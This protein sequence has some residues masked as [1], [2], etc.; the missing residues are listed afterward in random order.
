[1]RWTV[2]AALALGALAGCGP[3]KSA[4][5]AKGTTIKKEDYL[6]KGKAVVLEFSSGD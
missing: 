2:A 6:V 1:M 3:S 4:V 5:I